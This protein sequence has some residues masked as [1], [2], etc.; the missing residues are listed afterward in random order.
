MK[1]THFRSHVK[2]SKDRSGNKT[3]NKPLYLMQTDYVGKYVK[4][5]SILAGSSS[6]GQN[7]V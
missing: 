5:R 3:V 7:K 6:N 1:S 4:V 2:K